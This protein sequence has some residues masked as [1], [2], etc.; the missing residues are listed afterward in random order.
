MLKDAALACVAEE[1]HDI[2]FDLRK[3]RQQFLLP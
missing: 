1:V 3:I 2:G